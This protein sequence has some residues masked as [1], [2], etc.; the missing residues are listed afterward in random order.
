MKLNVSETDRRNE[1]SDELLLETPSNVLAFRFLLARN[2]FKSEPLIRLHA[3]LTVFSNLGEFRRCNAAAYERSIDFCTFWDLLLC[4]SFKS[5]TNSSSSQLL[6]AML[7]PRSSLGCSS[8]KTLPTFSRFQTRQPR[9][10]SMK[11]ARRCK[12][13]D[14]SRCEILDRLFATTKD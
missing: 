4:R 3:V 6:Q 9:S 14:K 2:A 5:Q 8:N 11:K 13:N 1:A 12:C 7:T 10:S